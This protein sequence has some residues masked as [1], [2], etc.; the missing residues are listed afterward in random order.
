[1]T[2][3][4]TFLPKGA[5]AL[6]DEP[7][8]VSDLAADA[9]ILIDHPC[10]SN[11][12]CGKCRV[13]FVEGAPAA[14]AAEERLVSR[15]DLVSGWRLSCQAV[16]SEPATIDVPEMSQLVG[17][18]TF[19]PATLFEGEPKRRITRHRVT[20]R[21]PDLEHQWALLDSLRMELDW[22]RPL[23]ASV[24]ALRALPEH[25]WEAGGAVT[26]DLDGD[27][28]V[29]LRAG[30]VN[31]AP[32]GVAVDLGSTSVA[33]A[34]IDLESGAVLE[35]ADGTNPQVSR[36]AD[37]IARIEHAQSQADGNETLHRLATAIVSELIER[38]AEE[39]GCETREIVAM[40]LA[41]NP[42]MMHT[43]LGVDVRPLGQA[44]YVGA[45]TGPMS[46]KA[47][48][49]GLSLHPAA[50]VRLF[51][52]V[53][54]NVGGDTVAAVIATGLDRAEG[55]QMMIDLGT[56]SEVVLGNRER[57]LATSTA[58][59]PAFE[60][61]CIGQ[62]MRAAPGAIDRVT[63]RRRGGIRAHVIGNMK[64]R[65]LCG[66]GLIDA[67]A[68]LRA[69]GIVDASGRM[70]RG[71]EL[72]S[73]ADGSLRS[74][75]IHGEH[76]NPAVVLA[77]PANAHGGVPVM[78]TDRDIRQLQ[79]IKG[80]IMAGAQILLDQWGAQ[81]DDVEAVHVAGAFGAHV[82][83]ASALAIGLLPPVDP[84]RVHF[85]GN[86]AGVGARMGLV[87]EQAWTR[88]VEFAARCEYVE[89]GFLPEYQEAFAE[90]MA[91][92]EVKGK[93]NGSE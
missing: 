55:L 53:R 65:G 67:A 29:S 36:G 87:D 21:E 68:A 76:G 77:P 17:L 81:W 82:R 46:V 57:A 1:M 79:L 59:G 91:F 15:E 20:L 37:V 85:V 69:G 40:T 5:T 38:V 2:A 44:P 45:W 6:V 22:P 43:F 41:G 32:L 3:Q 14:T 50:N 49:L 83:K 4:V 16:V 27:E 42:A 75:V 12:T 78:L 35:T 80:S 73:I 23:T 60:G 28:V 72:A 26:V 56:N 7:T 63:L 34:L 8:G 48:S 24:E 47:A 11:A 13:R 58:A 88:G 33:A 74:M 52:M 70:V 64:A 86:A 61:A 30:S 51:P 66:T 90:A 10:G 92:P 71:R 9:E 25:A 31:G 89:L 93:E 18:K 62:G 84:E 39:H 19:G 54:S